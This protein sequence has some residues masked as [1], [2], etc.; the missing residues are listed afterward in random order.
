MKTYLYLK[1]Q[2]SISKSK[3]IKL[4]KS[5]LWSINI[6]SI[7]YPTQTIYMC[8]IQLSNSSFVGGCMKFI[9]KWLWLSCVICIYFLLVKRESYMWFWQ[10]KLKN[11]N[12]KWKFKQLHEY[13]HMQDMH[14]S[15]RVV[16]MEGKERRDREL[17][18][19]SKWQ[20]LVFRS[21]RQYLYW[22]F[23]SHTHIMGVNSV[24]LLKW[25][26]QIS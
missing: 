14:E 1:L 16:W 10:K 6:I 22:T 19:K 4:S 21:F 9:C 3:A 26:L 7:I 12:L 15:E 2:I 24:I 5:F 25:T 18:H 8:P 11:G 17:Y 20:H 13:V 23:I